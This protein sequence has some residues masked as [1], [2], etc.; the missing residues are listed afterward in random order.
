[1]SELTLKKCINKRS[2]ILSFVKWVAAIGVIVSHAFP[3]SQGANSTDWIA[4]ISGNS[5][6]IGG[7]SVFIF[8]FSSGLLVSKSAEKTGSW[9]KY[10]TQRCNRIFPKLVFV[11]LLSILIGGFISSLNI[12]EYFTSISTYVY[13]LNCILIPIHSLPG[14]FTNNIYPNVVNGPLWTLPIEFICYISLFYCIKKKKV[15]D[16]IS[17]TLIFFF[18]GI[19]LIYIIKIP[20][21]YSLRG[22]FLPFFAFYEGAL[23][24]RY[25]EKIKLNKFLALLSI[26]AFICSIFLKCADLGILFFFAYPFVTM[27]YLGDISDKLSKL[28]NI[29]YEIYLVGWPIQQIVTFCFSG[30]I[31][32]YLNMF[33]SIPLSMVMAI[34]INKIFCI[35][36]K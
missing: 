30:I 22:Y 2:T 1:M 8:L 12:F 17:H 13:L 24:Y 20:F 28:G 36:K 31:N 7:I 27:I 35:I 33:I 11:I 25:K 23:F 16:H 14:V 29:S 4:V 32:P 34:I 5:I 10:M 3:L 9:K 21:L 6:G 19:F 15:Y 26:L 18:L